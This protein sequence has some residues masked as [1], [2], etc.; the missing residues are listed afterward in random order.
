[1]RKEGVYIIIV[2]INYFSRDIVAQMIKNKKANTVKNS[3][4][5]CCA[6]GYNQKLP[7]LIVKKIFKY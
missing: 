7:L 1:M 2:I 4:E 6:L 5:K 3:I